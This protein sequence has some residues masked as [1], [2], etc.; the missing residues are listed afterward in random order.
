MKLVVV[1]SPAKAKTINKHLGSEFKVIASLGHIRDLLPKSGS[2]IPEQEFRMIYTTI[3]KSKKHVEEIIKA[4]AKAKEIYLATDPDREG[5]AIS[6]H[7]AETIKEQNIL[8]PGVSFKRV[9]FNEVT[10]KAILAAFQAPRQLDANLINAQQTRRALDYLVGFTISPLLW[11]K[12]PGCR[13]AGRVQSVA[14]RLICEREEEIENF[15]SEEHWDIKLE[16][17]NSNKEPFAAR[18]T[19]VNGEKLEKFSLTTKEQTDLLVEKLKGQEFFV[20]SIEKKQQRRSSPPPFITSSLQ[21]EA[22]RKLGFSAK[23]TMQI[24]QKLYEGIEIEGETTGLITYMRTDGVNL[25]AEVV[26][27]IRSLIV[28]EFSQQY[29]PPVAKIYKSKVKNAQ[30]A[31]EAIRPTNVNFTPS[32]LQT[33]LEKDYYQLYE[34]IWKRT[35]SC[36][37]ENVVLDLVT[38]NLDSKDKEFSARAN[39]MSIAFD[40]FYRLYREGVDDEKEEESKLLPDLVEGEQVQLHNIKPQQHFTEP[41]PRYSEAS[42]VKKLEELGIGR[43]STYAPILSVLQERKYASLIKKRFIPEERGR[44]VTV[45]LKGFFEKYVRYEFTASL[46]TDLD[47][48]AA[49]KLEWKSLLKEFWQGF[50]SNIELVKEQKIS[51]IISYLEESLSCHLFGSKD[52]QSSS[53]NCPSCLKGQLC[54]KLGKFGA[55]LACSNYHECDF[56]KQITSPLNKD[57]EEG[58][59]VIE[60]NK[61]LGQDEKG[62]NIFLKKGPYGWYIQLGEQVSKET[63]PKRAALLKAMSP[64]NVNLETAIKL[65]NLPWNLGTHPKDKGEILVNIGKYGPYLKYNERF[66]AVPKTKDIYSLTLSQAVEIINAKDNSPVREKKLK[67]AK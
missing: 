64:A 38:A 61:L 52:P 44:L 21:Q 46:E 33:K 15:K 20:T 35:I 13:S 59:E 5:E 28:R 12:L 65:V 45:F 32:Y 4:A 41:P 57:Q 23:K 10:K 37:M 31:H 58:T 34:L 36:Q 48:I 54:L 49:G 40:G 16:M 27:Q 25:S 55:F 53:K 29:L 39:G 60:N 8:A 42:L 43:P 22:A 30:E 11:R 1:E 3:D 9:A 2:V 67:S 6:W 56:K 51:D 63:K 62:N 24:A 26:E 7:I 19:H 14:L 17:L 47:E 66:I 18:V 50:N